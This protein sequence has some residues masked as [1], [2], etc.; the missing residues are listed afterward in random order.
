MVIIRNLFTRDAII[1]YL[2][3]LGPQFPTPCMDVVFTDRP[4]QPGPLIGSDIIRQSV[5][6]M[7]LARRGGRS[8]SISGATGQ[9]EFYEPFPIHPDISVT[10]AELN[11]LRLF[12]QGGPNS[13]SLLSAWAQGKTDVLRRTVRN[14]TEAM[15]ATALSGKLEWPVQLEGGQFETYTIDYGP[16][17]TIDPANFVAWDDPKVK[18]GDIQELL[19]NIMVGFQTN[20]VGGTRIYWAGQKAFITLFNVLSR[21]FSSSKSTLEVTENTININGTRIELRSELYWDPQ[22]KGF[23]PIVPAGMLKAIATDAG[24]RLPYAAIDDLDGNLQPMPFFM[25][26]LKTDNPSGYS[27][28]AESKPLPVVNPLGICDV[29]VVTA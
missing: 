25:K 11:N 13:D 4:Q 7:P 6:A 19:I 22:T 23:K 8:I 14:T 17:Q 10:G 5:K 24:H 18:I 12:M 15:C 20:G 21:I 26:P 28:I 1:R 2:K 29:Q 9:T 16:V 27:L 3:I